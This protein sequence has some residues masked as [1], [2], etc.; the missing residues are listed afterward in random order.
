MS[1]SK[2]VLIID[3]LFPPQRVGNVRT[4][5]FVKYLPF[6]GWEPQVLTISMGGIEEIDSSVALEVSGE[7]KV[8]R[9]FYPNPFASVKRWKERLG[10][11]VSPEEGEGRGSGAGSTP[12]PA[13]KALFPL[14]RGIGYGLYLVRRYLLIPEELILWL[15]FAVL[16]GARICR[17]EGI[18]LIFSTAPF[19][20]NHLVALALKTMTGLPWVADYRNLWVDNPTRGHRTPLHRAVEER[21]DRR[22]IECSDKIVVIAEQMKE[23]LLNRYPSLKPEDVTCIGNGYDP[24]DFDFTPPAPER[25]R[26]LISYTGAIYDGYPT[27]QFLTAVGELVRGDP[28]MREKLRVAFYGAVTEAER[29]KMEGIIDGYGMRDIVSFGGVI[30]R[31]EALMQA[32]ASNALLLMFGGRGANIETVI[33]GKLYDYI[34]AGKPVIA[35]VPEGAAA[36]LVRRGNCGVVVDPDDTRGIKKAILRLYRS[37][38]SEDQP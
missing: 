7:V 15:P 32:A 3:N 29:D 10:H 35:V 23:F 34:A 19:F 17:G 26:F 5:K 14:K 20:V 27:A 8:H 22:V 4:V 11:R 9:A 31:R 18:D 21:L 12:N 1:G 13:I 33:P 30:P 2:R 38:G 25:D 37:R 24:S 36:E 6:Y 16:K 28:E